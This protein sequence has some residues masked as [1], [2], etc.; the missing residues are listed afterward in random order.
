MSKSF[1]IDKNKV[2]L[3][4]MGKPYDPEKVPLIDGQAVE[5]N[6][7]LTDDQCEYL[8]LLETGNNYEIYRGLLNR[9]MKN[10]KLPNF[11]SLLMT[12]ISVILYMTKIFSFGANYAFEYDCSSCAT[13]NFKEMNL[14]SLQIEYSDE[15][16]DYSTKYQIELPSGMK[17]DMHFL[18]LGDEK[19]I[20]D[21]TDSLK[22]K[23]RFRALD[24]IFIRRAAQVDAIDGKP[25]PFLMDKFNKLMKLSVADNEAMGKLLQ[26][27]DIG[28]IMDQLRTKCE[29]C[30]HI[31]PIDLGL[32]PDFFRPA[33][34]RSDFDGAANEI[35]DVREYTVI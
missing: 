3:P 21:L 28:L 16:E 2:I 33:A 11:D 22:K 27:R 12:D 8:T 6:E 24:K 4:S 9:V 15:R 26:G 7:F 20:G 10:P 32:G 30:G 25:A 18:T 1:I 13:K 14:A 23:G 34:K 29:A 5:V 17:L 19:K 35:S 31:E